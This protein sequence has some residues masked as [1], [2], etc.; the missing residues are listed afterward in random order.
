MPRP[1]V[2]LKVNAM[3]C[4][5]LWLG[6][7]G[8][9]VDP[10]LR[11]VLAPG[12]RVTVVT[13]GQTWT[14]GPLYLNDGRLLFADIKT[15]SIRAVD[16]QGRV[17]ILRR[18][19]GYAGRAPFPGPEP[20]SSAMA[21]DD[22]GRVVVAG[23]AGR[24]IFR[25]AGVP[26]ANVARET[27]VERFEGKRLNG[28]NDLALAADGAI[29]FTDPAYGLPSQSLDDPAHELDFAGVYR[30]SHPGA[31][32]QK[33]RLLTR[34]LRGP[35][36]LAFS[37]DGRT[38]YVADTPAK[39]W[40]KFEVRADGGLT[41]PTPFAAVGDDA[42]EGEP[43]G[44][45]VDRAGRVFAAG[46]GGVWVFTPSGRKL[47]VIAIPGK[48]SNLAFGGADRRT[49]YVTAGDTIYKIGLNTAP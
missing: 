38:L 26:G 3:F 10:G 25:Y 6:V 40:V 12:A 9:D 5:W 8:A 43:D 17:K 35:N 28:P 11:D 15:N 4:L 44:L 13:R 7:A 31:P 33:L 14:E 37:P 41:G 34:A 49:L 16:A 45:K 20:G 36:G 24:A 29:Y 42:R 32:D 19:S 30:L 46:P 22:R 48:T 1:R 47:G 21:R 27:L 2:D 23:H 39:A 18:P